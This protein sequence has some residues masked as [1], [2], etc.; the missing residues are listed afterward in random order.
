MKISNEIFV[1]S[2]DLFFTISLK[3]E[4]LRLG[5][6]NSSSLEIKSKE[7]VRLSSI[8]ENDSYDF[9]SSL[10][11][12]DPVLVSV[13]TAKGGALDFEDEE[14]D[15]VEE[16]ADGESTESSDEKSSEENNSDNS[17]EKSE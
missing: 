6:E 1:E 5:L 10:K 14:T 2:I 11:S 9:P 17:E 13:L 8:G 12:Q 3:F 16:G 7:K 4:I 15:D